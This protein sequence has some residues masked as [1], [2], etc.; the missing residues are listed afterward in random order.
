MGYTNTFKRY[1][2]KYIITKEQKLDIIK[3]ME[4]YMIPDA[5][6][7][8][9]IRNIYYDT[10]S[11]Q[12][13]RTSI[14]KPAYKEKLR[15]RSYKQVNGDETVFVELKKKY[16]KVVYKRRLDIP[17]N[18]ATS[19]LNGGEAPNDSQIAKEIDYFK[20]F[21]KGLKPAVFLSYDRE[22]FFAKDDHDF[23]ISF[24][25][26]ILTRSSDMSLTSE[27]YGDRVIDED[28]C[29]MEVK[30]AAGMP[31]WLARYLSENKIFKSSFSKYGTAYKKY[32][33]NDNNHVVEE[34]A[35]LTIKKVAMKKE[36]YYLGEAGVAYA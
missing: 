31:L 13:I 5:F 33:V 25:T 2:L 12:L 24:D 3:M 11:Y 28:M 35:P 29:I 14:D 6:G 26:N 1:E 36:N 30:V 4:E 27:V 9:T 16:D 17:E 19:W 10:D 7:A 23:R 15:V 8:T 18:I 20:D 22:A 21:Y 34:E 32:I